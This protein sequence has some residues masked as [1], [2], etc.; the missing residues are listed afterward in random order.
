MVKIVGR[1]GHDVKLQNEG[2]IATGWCKDNRIPTRGFPSPSSRSTAPSAAAVWASYRA[3]CPCPTSATIRATCP[4]RA[5]RPPQHRATTQACIPAAGRAQRRATIQSRHPATRPA[6][7]MESRRSRC[8]SRCRNQ[9]RYR[10]RCRSRCRSLF[11]NRGRN[12]F[13]TIRYPTCREITQGQTHYDS[14]NG[15]CI[16]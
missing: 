5:I 3:I 14:N 15:V 16:I 2:T 13:R 8:Q 4:H 6:T 11:L 7:P 10:N 9:N 1:V 12:Q